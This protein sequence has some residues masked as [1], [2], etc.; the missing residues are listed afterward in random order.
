MPTVPCQGQARG[1][2]L[3]T[4]LLLSG[5]RRGGGTRAGDVVN[6]HTLGARKCA[7]YSASTRCATSHGFWQENVCE[8]PTETN[9]FKND[10]STETETK[11]ER[12]WFDGWRVGHMWSTVTMSTWHNHRIGAEGVW[13]GTWNEHRERLWAGIEDLLRFVVESPGDVIFLDDITV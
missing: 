3:P 6:R 5:G 4:G 11:T 1:G 12:G 7:T 10:I 8:L 13:R 2:L 9:I